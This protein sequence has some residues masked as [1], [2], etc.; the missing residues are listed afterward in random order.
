MVTIILLMNITAQRCF[1][2]VYNYARYL[3]C[4]RVMLDILL[5]NHS[6]FSVEPL[7]CWLL[8]VVQAHY[9]YS[10]RTFLLS[11]VKTSL[12]LKIMPAL[13]AELQVTS[14]IC[15]QLQVVRKWNKWLRTLVKKPNLYMLKALQSKLKCF[16]LNIFRGSGFRPVLIL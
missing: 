13:L 1:T 9:A 15:W 5:V 16:M 4:T 12:K 10:E 11:I 7:Y 6:S 2:I 3:I 14:F 8:H